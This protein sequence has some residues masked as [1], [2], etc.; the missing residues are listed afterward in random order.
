MVSFKQFGMCLSSVLR[1]RG[2]VTWCTVCLSDREA[3]CAAGGCAAG[4]CGDRECAV[5]G[6]GAGGCGSCDS[7]GATYLWCC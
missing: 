7:N 3:G 6:C 5:G 2:V 4:G 1:C